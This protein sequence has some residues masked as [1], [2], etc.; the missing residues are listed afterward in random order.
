MS[1]ANIVAKGALMS[2]TYTNTIVM[3][4]IV[5]KTNKAWHTWESE[6]PIGA[7]VIGMER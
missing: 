1:I 7:Y 2:H 3:L 5:T 4:D 6:V